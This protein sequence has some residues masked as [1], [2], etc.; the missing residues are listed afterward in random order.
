M[1]HLTTELCEKYPGEPIQQWEYELEAKEWAAIGFFP[2]AFADRARLRLPKG[3]YF[4]QTGKKEDVLRVW[5]QIKLRLGRKV[6]LECTI[7]A[8]FGK[9]LE[10][11]ITEPPAKPPIE[12]SEVLPSAPLEDALSTAFNR[13]FRLPTPESDDRH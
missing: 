11:S 10:P 6:K 12:P 4:S 2:T 8:S 3:C 1:S 7:G 5:G 9:D 13:L